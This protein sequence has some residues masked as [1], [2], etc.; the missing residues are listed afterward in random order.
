MSKQ[1]PPIFREVQ[2]LPRAKA[3]VLL[4]ASALT[5]WAVAAGFAIAGKT[6]FWAFLGVTAGIL[7]AAGAASAVIL[8]LKMVTE[9]HPDG[10]KIRH[11][12]NEVNR[13]LSLAGIR[14]H[15]VVAYDPRRDAHGRGLKSGKGWQAYTLTGQRGV[16]LEYQ[17][18]SW[19]LI[20]SQEPEA[21]SRAIALALRDHTRG[22]R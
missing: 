1:P 3:L 8:S 22:P 20:G 21:L 9:V 10:V 6:Q 18:G 5:G 2:R 13:T 14:R 16:R 19:A 12:G 4:A 11:G 15:A 17:D 7:G